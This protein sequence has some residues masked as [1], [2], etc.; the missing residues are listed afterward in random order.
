MTASGLW[1]FIGCI[2]LIILTVQDYKNKMKVDDRYNFFMSGATIMLFATYPHTIW[3]T[4][5]VVV[6]MIIFNLVSRNFKGLGL[7]DKNT[8]TWILLG[9]LIIYPVHVVPFGI[10]LIVYSTFYTLLK[11]YLF[12]YKHPT[13]FYPVIFLSF[14]SFGLL[15]KLF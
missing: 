2:Y 15:Y 5:L 4:W 8:L 3:Y 9:L 7:G 12:K 11:V 14:L 13:P 1:F 10:I 6:I